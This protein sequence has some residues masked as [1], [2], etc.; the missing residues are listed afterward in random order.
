MNDQEAKLFLQQIRNVSKNETQSN[1]KT[2]IKTTPAYVISVNGQMATVRLVTDLTGANPFNVPIITSQTI[3]PGDYV[4]L[5]YWDNLSTAVIFS[6]GN[7]Y[8]VC[9]NIPIRPNLID[10]AYFVGG[11]AG[12]GV[13]PINQRG[14]SAYT[15]GYGID[16]WYGTC[17]LSLLVDGISI[18]KSTHNEP[19]NQVLS[20]Q[21]AEM[22]KGET[23]TFSVLTT[24]GQLLTATGEVPADWESSPTNLYLMR[25]PFA[26]KMY[27]D[28][29]LQS[30]NQLPPRARLVAASANAG[31]SVS[32]AA[33]KLEL[34][35]GQTLAY[36]KADGTWARLPQNLD[37]QQELAKCQAYLW[38]GSKLHFHAYRSAGFNAVIQI[39][40]PVPMR[41]DSPA[42]T[43]DGLLISSTG[44]SEA[45]TP[46]KTYG[47]T[48]GILM[49]ETTVSTLE[50]TF[51]GDAQVTGITVN[52]EL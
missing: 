29:A 6:G 46:I 16:R 28:L 38:R 21:S 11:G 12:W 47:A 40:L 44:A 34:G 7:N 4:N 52:A 27:F 45:I 31:D 51:V 36:K 18:A 17:N 2:C 37:Y 32:V 25:L 9:P 42:V 26:N 14:Q 41:V 5:A 39:P 8:P 35:E 22:I 23:L 50:G 3:S 10:N 15:S 13:F 1:T 49:V 43:I 24:D 33:I 30:V 19:F 48:S 20:P